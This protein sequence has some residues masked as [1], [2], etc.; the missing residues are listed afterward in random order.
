MILRVLEWQNNVIYCHAYE[1][2]ITLETNP[3]HSQNPHSYFCHVDEGNIT[4]NSHKKITPSFVMLTKKTSHKK[5][6]HKPTQNIHTQFCHVDEGNIPQENN[7]KHSQNP[8]SYFCHVD[9]GNITRNSHKKITP[10]FVML[11]KKT[12]HK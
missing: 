8:H 6:T 1:E 9:E 5:I 2:N 7:P 4:R 10:S 12:S 11:T 3:K